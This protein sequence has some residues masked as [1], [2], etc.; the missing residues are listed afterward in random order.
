MMREPR[1]ESDYSERQVEAAYRVLVDVGQVLASFADCL[2][3]VGGWVPDL[4]ISDAS[5]P[6]VGSI[7]VDIALDAA[8]LNDGRYAELLK[9]LIGTGRYKKGSKAFQLVVEVD[10]KD[11]D[12]PVQVD[13]EFLAPKD[14]KLTKNNLKQFAGFR[15]LKA[16]AC[17]EA[18]KNPEQLSIKGRTI[19]GATNTVV[20]RVAAVSDF[21]LMKAYAIEGRDKPNSVL[22]KFAFHGSSLPVVAVASE[23][24][25]RPFTAFNWL[26][27]PMISFG[28]PRTARIS[29][30]LW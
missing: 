5:V 4:L 10:L 20:V 13:V 19:R 8:R 18:F 26:S 27:S 16:E 23:Q 17:I 1:N 30:Q 22:Q 14:V 24:N 21:L 9:L 28:L 11:G 25:L 3:I 2:V 12:K 6:H 7:D 29:R 15:V